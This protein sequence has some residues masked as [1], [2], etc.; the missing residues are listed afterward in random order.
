MTSSYADGQAAQTNRPAQG[1]PHLM[2]PTNPQPE[3]PTAHQR[4]GSRGHPWPPPTG[5]PFTPLSRPTPGSAAPYLPLS[6]PRH[7]LPPRTPPPCPQP[8]P[9]ETTTPLPALGR[10]TPPASTN[11]RPTTAPGRRSCPPGVSGLEDTCPLPLIPPPVMPAVSP[12]S[13]PRRSWPWVVGGIVLLLG[14]LGI[15]GGGQQSSTSTVTTA[16]PPAVPAAPPAA[17]AELLAAPAELLAAPAPP[18]TLASAFGE[19][20][21]VVGIGLFPGTYATTGLA[22]GGIGRCSW[23]R[24]KDTSGNLDSTIA[25]DAQ[26]GPTTVTITTTDGAFTTAGCTPWQEVSSLDPQPAPG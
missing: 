23:S 16:E 1:P 18:V 20:T 21:Y 26:Q 19:G 22:V 8:L 11:P 13:K 5:E 17:P 24:L 3:H 10:L 14:I 7:H 25:T 2:T 6:Q 15:V 9:T 4:S 12:A